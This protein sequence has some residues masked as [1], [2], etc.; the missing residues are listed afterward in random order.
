MK[1]NYF[2]LLMLSFI[3]FRAQAQ[4]STAAAAP[5]T[6]NSSDVVSLFSDAY[7]N[8][9][10]TDFFPNWGQSTVV[11]DVTIAGNATK[12]YA[13]LNYQG[14]QLASSINV[15]AMTSLHVDIWTSNC[16]ALD[17]F[18]INT[19]PSTVQ[20][21]VTLT[22]T[23]SGWNSF[24]IALSQYNTIALNNVGQLMLVGTPSGTSTVYVDNLYFWKSSNTPTITGFTVP[25]KLVGDAPFT[26]TDPTS[27][28]IGA[29]TY[30]SSN[31]SV[32]TISGKT[33]TILAGGTCIITATQA[34]AGGF[35]AG[36]VSASLIVKYPGLNLA[37]PNPPARNASDVVSI[38]S[39]AYT[40]VAGTDF[41]P[42]W[43][44]STTQT[45]DT[46][47]GNLTKHF[48]NFNYQGIQ[49]A[50][51]INLSAMTTLHFDLYTPNCTS[52]DFFLINTTG[53]VKEQS[54]TVTPNAF[55]WNSY[56]IALSQ[57]N[58]IDLTKVGQLKMVATP[59]GSS[60]VYLDNIYFW[61]NTAVANA[62]PTT[63]APTPP[64]RLKKDVI[65]LYSGAYT[66]VAGTDFFPNWGQTTVVSDTVIVGDTTMKYATFNYQGIQLDSAKDVSGM[67]KLHV[68]IWTPNCTTFEVFLINTTPTVVEQ[69]VSLSPTLLGWNS[70]DID[71]TKY[72]N[73]ALNNVGQLKLV[74]TPFGSSTVYL[75]NI[76][77]WTDSIKVIV[78]GGTKQI[79]L[80]VTFDDTTYN[81]TVTDFGN[82]QTVDGVDPTNAT[83]RVKITTKAV[84]AETWAGTTV[85]TATGFSSAIPITANATKMSLR[86]YAPAAGI[87]VRLKIEDHTNPAKSV[88]TEATTTVANG[89][90]TLVF[91]FTNQ[92][93]GTAPINYTYKYDMASVFFDF[94]NPGVGKVFYWDDLSFGTTLPVKFA[95][96]TATKMENTAALNWET[97]TELNNKGFEVQ[98]SING[99]NW[100]TIQF[101]TANKNSA[102][103][104]ESIDKAPVKAINY[105]RLKQLD[106]NGQFTYSNIV[107]VNFRIENTLK[108]SF[109]PNPAKNNVLVSVGDFTSNT[110]S[111]E[112]VN[113]QGKKVLA[114]EVKANSNV[115]IDISSLS[116]GIYF[117]LLKD[118]T[119]IQSSKLVVE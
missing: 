68:D 111:L 23:L 91:D 83:N 82:N 2:L 35:T 16:T 24:D 86:V 80:P 4:P 117:M 37:A 69:K 3:M 63:A 20:Q 102:N 66:K 73:I 46:I 84:G 25:A 45:N 74:A 56:D 95:S 87:H 21:K 113:I 59:S 7:T 18:L 70:Y 88:E 114:R 106:I 41:F 1:K 39:G 94:G 36:S 90:E 15:S 109:Y 48:E 67:K 92:A 8:V 47:A 110:A 112:L 28:S 65:S 10:G 61:K 85:S 40:N 38:F 43:G 104:Y 75:D 116:K 50:S 52:F 49:F 93:S 54:I 13:T 78:I 27:N 57:F 32:A 9:T 107:S 31:T 101:V 6:R 89:W 105:Y 12:K 22:P 60:T 79:N 100:A 72:N 51:D 14:I 77:F 33:V 62:V 99:E 19:S 97:A 96:F 26:L 5:P 30:T 103:K 17:V 44:Q 108:Y 76:Y 115:S 81:Y 118:G 11:S 42:N 71:L 58:T 119:T 53:T 98:R 34:A 29:F 55:G 64:V